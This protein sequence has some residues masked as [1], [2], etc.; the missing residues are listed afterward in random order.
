MDK[1]ISKPLEP[2]WRKK[3]MAGNLADRLI[4]HVEGVITLTPSQVTAALG[5]MKKVIPDLSSQ[6]VALD[7]TA[8]KLIINVVKFADK[9]D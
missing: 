7:P 6:T 9:D 2:A 8:N 5:L 1:R 3:I 4:K